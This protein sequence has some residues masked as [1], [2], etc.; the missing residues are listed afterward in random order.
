[1]SSASAEKNALRAQ[2]RAC[3]AS[4]PQDALGDLSRRLCAA[5]GFSPERL[6][7]AVRFGN[8]SYLLER[9]PAIMGINFHIPGGIESF[10]SKG[11]PGGKVYWKPE[12]KGLELWK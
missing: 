4:L 6:A 11:I 1:M 2:Y 8:L 7:E 3:R 10:P 12:K 5:F 9:L